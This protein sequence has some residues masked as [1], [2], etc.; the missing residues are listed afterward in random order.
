MPEK[1][2][3][4]TFQTLRKLDQEILDSNEP[5]ILR[6]KVGIVAVLARSGEHQAL[7]YLRTL[8]DVDP[9]RRP[10]VAM[11]LAQWPNEQNWHYLVRSL[12]ILDGGAA[13]EVL[14]NLRSINLAPQEP[15]FYRQVILRGLQL[16]DEGGAEAVA[17]LELWTG[18]RLSHH[19]D[20]AT[21]LTAWQQW[22]SEQWPDLP[23]AE[24]PV[25]HVKGKWS[26]NELVK[27]LTMGDGRF[28]SFEN[29]REVFQR[30]HCAKCHR[31]G[32]MGEDDAP[33]LTAL[34]RRAMKKEILESILFPS[35]VLPK[36]Y[37]SQT[38]VT[39]RGR[40]YSGHIIQQGTNDQL[41]LVQ[42]DDRVVTLSQADV[43][44]T[45]PERASG[46][47]EGLLDELTLQEVAD[48]FAY[49]CGASEQRL[50]EAPETDSVLR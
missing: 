44:E 29:G 26:Y 20:P 39:T 21:A 45:L 43:E 8:W 35:H 11:G 46:M 49:L 17:L 13:R 2:D 19:K 15:E 23:A 42:P 18:R 7:S 33:D 22:Y 32:D 27:Y 48:L 28:G 1:L 34:S 5:D 30:V 9:E 38:V 50:V 36:S 10:A 12:P 41:L 40:K 14:I 6:L 4:V 24:L 16:G 3:H 31:F 37:A 25:Y 47:P